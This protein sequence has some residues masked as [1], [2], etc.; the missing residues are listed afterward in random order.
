MEF[1]DCAKPGKFQPPLSPFLVSVFSPSA[2]IPLNSSK[3]KMNIGCN[4]KAKCAEIDTTEW[5]AYGSAQRQVRIGN[6]GETTVPM[7]FI[8]ENRVASFAA[9]ACRVL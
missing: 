4:R 1:S 8:G 2:E 5:L 7:P 6:S 9:R 3:A